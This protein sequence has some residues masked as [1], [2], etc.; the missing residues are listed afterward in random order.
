MALLELGNNSLEE[1]AE[2]AT[3]PILLNFH[4]TWCGPCKML[5]PLVLELA[6]EADDL[7]D[8][9]RI[10]IDEKPELAEQM[11]VNVVPTLIVIKNNEITNKST[12]FIPK[13][14]ILELLK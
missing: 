11:D 6:E 3:K 2:K 4:A 14:D 13:A 8:V 5:A 9:Y 12:G 1:I 7:M 10:D